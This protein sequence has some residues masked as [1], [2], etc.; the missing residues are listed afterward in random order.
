MTRLLL[1]GAPGSGKGTQSTALSRVYSVPAISTGDILRASVRDGG[2]P[3]AE[4]F[5]RH[6]NSGGIPPASLVKDVVLGRLRL[7]DCGSGFLLDGYPRLLEQI[8]EL[9]EFLYEGGQRLDAAVELAVDDGELRRRLT[10]R[11]MAFDRVDDEPEIV[12]RRLEVYR[13]ATAPLID[14]YN[15]RGLLLRIDGDGSNEEV[16]GRVVHALVEFGIPHGSS[17]GS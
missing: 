3:F 10:L 11:H 6:M 4:E 12:I 5:K 13:K 9:D 8:E 7:P 1:I 14:V 17:A 2:P 16:T 15:R